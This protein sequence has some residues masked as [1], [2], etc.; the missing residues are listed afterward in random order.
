MDEERQG[1]VR[2]VFVGS[3]SWSF[4]QVSSSAAVDTEKRLS[5][6]L[7]YHPASIPL[8]PFHTKGT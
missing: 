7:T 5:S 8:L 3:L 1:N 2:R 6:A 4:S